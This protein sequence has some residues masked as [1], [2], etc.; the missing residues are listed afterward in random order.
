M[1]I[2]KRY[3]KIAGIILSVF[4]LF[5][6]IAGV[7]AYNKRE[8]LLKA[9]ITKAVR[10]A[11]NDYDLNVTIQNARFDGLRTVKLHQIAVVPEHRDSLA[12]IRDLSVSVKLMPLLFGHVRLLNLGLE[13][14]RLMLVK[15]DS[16]R[17][18]DF[19]FRKKNDDNTTV[20]QKVDLSEL[21]N[22]LLNQMLDKVP[23]DMDVKN[24]ALNIHHDEDSLKFH[25][26]NAQI[27]DSYLTSTILVNK[28][29][30]IWH[31]EGEIDASDKQLDLKLYAEG[32]KVE[33][34]FIQRKFDLK[35]SFDTVSTRLEKVVKKGHELR[36]Y[37]S[38][39]VKNLLINHPKAAA[40]DIIIP[41]G[42]IDAHMFIGENYISIDSSSVIH[43]K[44]VKANPYIK[45]ALSPVKTY[46]LNLHTEE[47]D[48]QELFDAFPIGMFESLQ[49]IKVAGRLR[50][51]LNLYLNT[52]HP[53][54]VK[55]NSSLK[56]EDFRVLEWGQT[57]LD[58]INSTFVYTPY[59]YGKPMRDIIVGPANPNYTPLEEISPDLKNAI[60]TAEDP[61]FF[62]HRG[63][64]EESIRKSIATNF[65]EKAFKRGGSTISMQLVKN[66]FLNRQKTLVRKIEEILIVWIME[67]THVSTKQRMFEVYLNII[68]WGK[69]IYG[70]GEAS[71]YYFAKHP[72]QLTLGES[73]YLASI[74]P[75][76][77]S[78]LYFFEPDGSLRS[79]LR[80]YFKLIGNLMAKRG[81]AERDTNAYG[82]YNVRLKESLRWGT[83]ADTIGIDSLLFEDETE[84]QQNLLQRIFGKRERRRDTIHI[85][86]L[87]KLRTN[88]TADTV[89]SPEEI[90]QEKREE[91]RRKRKENGG[92]LGIF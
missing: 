67:N 51:D 19:L 58:K 42:S 65:K 66:V 44:N 55:F 54:Q 69:N 87:N 28:K 90:R 35:L 33:L 61:S 49:G 79:S 17:N 24:F 43:L 53:D 88:G 82:F 77:K 13:D 62:S 40:N 37:G 25:V 31:A 46:E 92:F 4:L 83:P 72:S 89:K 70:I 38:W 86:D 60:L 56:G 8:K 14:G 57:N 16:L 30:S 76:P 73:I 3:L 21:A 78:G 7:V 15:R 26:P 71:H 20:K 91:R 11:K 80:G 81:W 6:L 5:V 59:E 32:K 52:K 12:F 45:Y 41:S 34:P 27:K 74:V 23:D 47:L 22:K 2:S 1:R 36:I 85:N 48:A 50:Y 39:A 29:E 10:K 64:V 68:E 84:E 18:Y 9:A 63:F 75:R